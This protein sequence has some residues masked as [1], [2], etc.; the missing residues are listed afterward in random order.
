MAV[1]GYF[2][3]ATNR[4]AR[5]MAEMNIT[6][7]VDVMLVLLVIFMVSAPAL[8]G[9]LDLLLPRPSDERVLPPPEITLRVEQDGRFD[10]EGRSL[11][12]DALPAALAAIAARA[13]NT[14][15]H[16]DANM[17]ADYQAFMRAIAASRASG[18]NNVALDE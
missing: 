2:D 5:A 3:S 4:Q 16:I 10:L 7:L 15:V 8:T 13:P 11:T 1:S 6:P 12:A 9:R 18:L 17:D 14:L